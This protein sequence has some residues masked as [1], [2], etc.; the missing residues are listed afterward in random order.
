MLKFLS[1]I[2]WFLVL[3]VTFPSYLVDSKSDNFPHTFHVWGVFTYSIVF[4]Q[5]PWSLN[6][7]PLTK[8]NQE[9]IFSQAKLVVIICCS[10]ENHMPCQTVGYVCQKGLR[11]A[12]YRICTCIRWF[13]RGGGMNRT[14]LSTATGE[15]TESFCI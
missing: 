10:R 5:K 13:G 8:P 11:E 2:H 7:Y 3:F 9:H 12:C 1:Q 4:R 14:L 6:C 15:E